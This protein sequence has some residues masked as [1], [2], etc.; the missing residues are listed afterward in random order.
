MQQYTTEQNNKVMSQKIQEVEEKY[1]KQL[2]QL[3]L[4]LKIKNDIINKYNSSRKAVKEFTIK[5]TQDRINFENKRFFERMDNS[6][7]FMIAKKTDIDFQK[8]L[9]N[10]KN[11]KNVRNS[12]EYKKIVM[13]TTYK[14]EEIKDLKMRI[15]LTKSVSK[16]LP[17]TTFSIKD[18]SFNKI[19]EL[20]TSQR[21]L[22]HNEKL[23]SIKVDNTCKVDD[24][25]GEIGEIQVVEQNN[26]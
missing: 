15:K 13:G 9:S 24:L 7:P 21:D 18:A 25:C 16:N 14:S 1:S 23:N 6:N 22:I 12:K 10:I 2:N 4:K 20:S 19:N 8:T 17:A 11:L 26:Q 5:E 3:Y